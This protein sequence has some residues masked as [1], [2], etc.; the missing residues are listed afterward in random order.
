MSIAEGVLLGKM[1]RIE[2]ALDVSM[3]LQIQILENLTG[4]DKEELYKKCTDRITELS[5]EL[6]HQLPEDPGSFR[7]NPY[8]P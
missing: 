6:F 8:K 3:K 4:A 1:L 5:K 2:A 7:K